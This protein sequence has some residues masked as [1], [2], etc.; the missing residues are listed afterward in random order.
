MADQFARNNMFFVGS[1]VVGETAEIYEPRGGMSIEN[2]LLYMNFWLVR[3]GTVVMSAL[4][5]CEY[6]V[7]DRDAALVAGLSETGL[8]ADGEG[9]Y[10]ATP[11]AATNLED[12]N[13]YIVEVTITYDGQDRVSRI[14]VGI[15]E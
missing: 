13:H 3:N 8:T 5:D 11:V 7:F 1:D 9:I 6:R 12:L 4:G 10:T 14:P 2:N 15:V